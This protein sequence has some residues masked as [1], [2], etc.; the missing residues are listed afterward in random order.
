MA[1]FTLPS[2]R[3]VATTRGDSPLGVGASLWQRA[4]PSVS[5]S[6][7]YGDRASHPQQ[8]GHCLLCC[9]RAKR[10]SSAGL[11]PR[12]EYAWY[13]P[14]TR[15]FCRSSGVPWP[16]LVLASTYLDGEQGPGGCWLCQPA[17]SDWYWVLAP[18]LFSLPTCIRCSI[19]ASPGCRATAAPSLDSV[20]G[21]VRK[22]EAN[23]VPEPVIKIDNHTDPYH[24]IVSITYGDRLGE[25][26]DTVSPL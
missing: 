1:G 8:L 11:D 17:T 6:A 23:Q 26:S 21:M 9:S 3:L 24:T 2:E 22:E 19:S 16:C 20:D 25:L 7:G 13:P 15:R 18:R 5:P 14:W 4:V 10:V 12:S